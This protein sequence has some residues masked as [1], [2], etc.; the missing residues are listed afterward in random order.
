MDWQILN[1]VEP[2]NEKEWEMMQNHPQWGSEIVKALQKL[3]TIVPAILHHHENFDGSGYPAGL[4]GNDIP[5]LARIIRIADSFDA[6]TSM[7]PYRAP[8]SVAKALQEIQ[9]NAGTQFD[10]QLAAVFIE[11]IQDEMMQQ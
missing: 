4:K 11:I 2:L 9:S 10:P 6:M 3:H 5:A 1:K 8:L 7:R